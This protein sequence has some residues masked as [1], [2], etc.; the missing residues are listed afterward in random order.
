MMVNVQA[1]LEA[2]DFSPHAEQVVVCAAL[3]AQQ[4]KATLHL[5]H[6]LPAISWKMFGRMLSEHPL[7]TEKQLYEAA[8]VR[9][10][11]VADTCR[12]R[13]AIPVQF[14]VEIDRPHEHI[15]DYAHLHAVN[16]TILGSHAGNFAHDLFIGSTAFRFLHGGTHPA[17]IAKT[18][19]RAPHRTVLVTVDFSDISRTAI[20]SAARIVPGAVIHALHVYDVLFEGKMRYAGGGRGRDPAISRCGGCRSI[21]HDA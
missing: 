6:V 9:L 8:K 12:K 18:L 17:L 5:L 13:Y 20:G 1:I 7:V 19:P 11:G 4:H 16:Q 3:L 10:S 2:T 21:A 15:A 14:H